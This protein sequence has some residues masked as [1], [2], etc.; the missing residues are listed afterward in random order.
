MEIDAYGVLVIILSI[1][2]AVFLILAIIATVLIIRVLKHVNAI[3]EKA[4]LM[5]D[6]L[7]EASKNFSKV[8]GPMAIVQALGG[9]FKHK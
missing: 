7:Q 8:A 1:T 4:E 6:N 5:A 2:L 9:I 3:S